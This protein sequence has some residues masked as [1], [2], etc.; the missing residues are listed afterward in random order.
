MD[1]GPVQPLIPPNQ[2]P[3]P[4]YVIPQQPVVTNQV[5]PQVVNVINYN[6]GT[7]PIMMNCQFCKSPINTTVEKQWNCCTCCLCWMTGLVFFICVQSCRGKELC[8]YD[9]VHKCP[10]CGQILGYYNS[11]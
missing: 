9:A 3:Q 5:Q 7:T 10:N 2:S 8:C 11:C 4:G 6:F 1:Q